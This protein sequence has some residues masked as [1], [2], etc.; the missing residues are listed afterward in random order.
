MLICNKYYSNKL[1]E[2][3]K[4]TFNISDNDISK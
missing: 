2:I 3:L 4:N 1:Y